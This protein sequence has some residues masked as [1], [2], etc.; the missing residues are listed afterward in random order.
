MNTDNLFYYIAYWL[1]VLAMFGFLYMSWK[2]YRS[3]NKTKKKLE[4][5]HNEKDTRAIEKEAIKI[6]QDYH[7]LLAEFIKSQEGSYRSRNELLIAK[8]LTEISAFV[9]SCVYAHLLDEEINK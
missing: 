4:K 3:G 9:R 6:M 8:E 5:I 1:Q 2:N 7:N